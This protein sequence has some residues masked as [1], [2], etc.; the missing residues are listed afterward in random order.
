MEAF[1]ILMNLNVLLTFTIRYFNMQN[2]YSA[3]TAD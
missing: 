1:F 2:L 3:E